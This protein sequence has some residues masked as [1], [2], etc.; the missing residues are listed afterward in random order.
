MPFFLKYCAVSLYKPA[1]GEEDKFYIRDH[2]EAIVSEE[3]FE[4]AQKILE[5]SDRVVFESVIEKM[6]IGGYN[7]EGEEDQVI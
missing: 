5:N 6:I 3:I 7:D 4:E 1:F 2:H